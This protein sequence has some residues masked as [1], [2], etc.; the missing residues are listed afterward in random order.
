MLSIKIR[1]ALFLIEYGDIEG[2]DLENALEEMSKY[3]MLISDSFIRE[4]EYLKNNKK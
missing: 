1:A 2:D 4:Y 3:G